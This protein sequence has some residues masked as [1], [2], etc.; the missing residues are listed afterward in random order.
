[1]ARL[2]LVAGMVV[3]FAAGTISVAATDMVPIRQDL[4]R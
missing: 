1:M 2:L 4:F 3:V